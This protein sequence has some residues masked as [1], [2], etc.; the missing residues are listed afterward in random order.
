MIRALL[1]ALAPSSARLQAAVAAAVAWLLAG[2]PAL[3]ADLL[4][5]SPAAR[6]ALLRALRSRH[7][8]VLDQALRPPPAA[9]TPF[10]AL[11]YHVDPAA[12]EVLQ[13]AA[14]AALAAD[15][16]AG[17]PL[18]PTQ[19]LPSVSHVL[20][21][22]EQRGGGRYLEAVAA[23]LAGQ[24]RAALLPVDAAL[25][26]ALLAQGL[27]GSLEGHLG[28]LAAC[29]SA[30]GAGARA[31]GRARFAWEALREA[32][33]RRRGP[34]VVYIRSADALICS[35]WAAFR[36]FHDVFGP[37]DAA[38]AAQR[39]PLGGPLVLIG[40]ALLG[41]SGAAVSGGAGGGGPRAGRR[42]PLKGLL[43]GERRVPCCIVAHPPAPRPPH[44][45]SVL[46]TG[47]YSWH[48]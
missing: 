46:T 41:E 45:A 16:Q 3:L 19:L 26:A 40:G 39:R 2:L 11:D 25:L 43:G 13:C 29:C 33:R 27:G 4:L 7:A 37:Q 8:R 35:S 17:D 30:A 21:Q 47:C 36:A 20:L 24:M 6:R 48:R 18:P 44:H 1:A 5:T 22:A 28:T 9:P 15:L 32:L 42:D 12:A 38:G 14:L 10:A 23:A 31:Q 34:T